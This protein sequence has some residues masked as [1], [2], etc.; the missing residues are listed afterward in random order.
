[1]R[2]LVGVRRGTSPSASAGASWLDRARR[3][4]PA[5]RQRPPLRRRAPGA[6]RARVP[7]YRVRASVDRPHAHRPRATGRAR[8][9]LV[10]VAIGLRRDRGP[11]AAG[12]RRELR[13]HP[14]RARRGDYLGDR[15]LPLLE[16]AAPRRRVRAAAFEM[17]A[18]GPLLLPLGLALS[19]QRVAR[20]VGLVDPVP[21]SGSSTWSS[22]A[23]SS[24]TPPT[25][26]SSPTSRSAP[27]RRTPT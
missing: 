6:D 20:P 23:R 5:R 1:M 21:R 26:G 11:R 25:S 13:R 24:A 15:L 14:A 3:R 7:D 4:P 12:G 19:G 17:L 9:S 10:G 18:G 27:S 22:S 8:A 16:A 2:G